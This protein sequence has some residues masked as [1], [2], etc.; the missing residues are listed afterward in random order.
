MTILC[1]EQFRDLGGGQ[2]SLLDAIPGLQKRGWNPVVAIPGE[3]SLAE[4]VRGL[5]CDVELFEAPT[6][7]NG[8]KRAMDVARYTTDA[9]KLT[10]LIGK[11]LTASKADLIYVNASRMLPMASLAARQRSIPLVFHCHNR[12]SQRTA[13]T[14]LGASLQLARA[15]VISCCKYSAEPL[16]RYLPEKALSI[17]YNGVADTR[18]SRPPR[19]IGCYRVGVIGRIEPEKGQLEF[20]AAARLMLRSFR[21]CEF[22]V[23]GAPLF[24]GRRYFERVLE[25]SRGL[26]IEFLGWQSDI[27][28][29]L[30]GLDVLV[31]PSGSLDCTPRV[32]VEAFAAGVPVVAFPSGG[33]PEIVCDGT[34]GFLTSAFTPAAM[35]E[36]IGSVLQLDTCSRESVVMNARNCWR[37][38]YSLDGFRWRVTNVIARAAG[39]EQIT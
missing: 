31:V 37:S 29:V 27:P 2:L 1:V 26:P 22:V 9:P 17:V 20:V 3:G 32:I 35:A 38:R 18:I 34:N 23:V 30:S 6:Y 28:A 15:L 7:T 5:H 19:A 12:V 13:M 10:R 8:I 39:C 24:G 14:L 25:A 33:I 11:L 21:K 36:R 4:R 16:R